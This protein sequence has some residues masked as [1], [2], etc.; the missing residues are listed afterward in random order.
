MRTK[1]APT[2]D[3]LVERAIQDGLAE[4][5]SQ[6][7]PDIVRGNLKPITEYQYERQLELWNALVFKFDFLILA[8]LS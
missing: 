2:D 5:S 7:S 6:H 4:D 3:E 8:F 1:S